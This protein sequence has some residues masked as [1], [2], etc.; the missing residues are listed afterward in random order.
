M[1]KLR[2]YQAITTKYLGPS[3]VRGSRIK[4]SAAAGSV[5]V[6]YDDSLNSEN[7]H[8]AAAAKL[9]EKFGWTGKYYIG[10]LPDDRGYVFVCADDVPAFEFKA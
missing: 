8:A 9:A 7:A 4:A 10:G 5:I 6:S 3:N 2:S 1:T